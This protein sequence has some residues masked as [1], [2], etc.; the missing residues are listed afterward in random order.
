MGHFKRAWGTVTLIALSALFIALASVINVGA[1]T[2]PVEITVPETKLSVSGYAAPN[3]LVQVSNNSS[4]SSSV[5]ADSSG[6]FTTTFVSASGIR[7]VSVHFVDQESVASKVSTKQVSVN[8]QTTTSVEFVL[9]PTLTRRGPEILNSGKVILSG[10]SLPQTT[11]NLRLTPLQTRTVQSNSNGF[12]EFVLP[13]TTLN[14]GSYD[15]VTYVKKTGVTS[16]DSIK[17]FFI[18]NN[19]STNAQLDFVAYTNL[20]TSSVPPPIAETPENESTITDESVFVSGK[21]TPNSQ[22]VIYEDGNI[23]GSVAADENGQWS[24]IYTA[25]YSPVELSFEACIN[26]LCSVLSNSL[27]LSFTKFDRRCSQTTFELA[28]YRLYNKLVSERIS[29]DVLKTNGDGVVT[30][31]WGDDQTDERFD[32]DADRPVQYSH[33]YSSPGLYNA[34]IRFTQDDCSITRYFSLEIT[35]SEAGIIAWSR[36]YWLLALVPFSVVAYKKGIVLMKE[37]ESRHSA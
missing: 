21:A 22:I 1:K 34:T 6:F 10:Y 28:R 33:Q 8:P 31:D 17:K 13:L 7:T 32:H 11:V 19:K 37:E 12:Y 35:E 14:P 18:Y 4:L 25:S 9:P 5:L 2:E 36:V 24:F 27:S 30:I 29:I 16:P 23:I 26:G 3:A 15:A 20:E